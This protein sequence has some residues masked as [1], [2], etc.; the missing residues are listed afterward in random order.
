MLNMHPCRLTCPTIGNIPVI[1]NMLERKMPAEK[2]HQALDARVEIF[3][4][5]LCCGLFFSLHK[6]PLR[7]SLALHLPVALKIGHLGQLAHLGSVR[8]GK[9]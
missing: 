8:Q 6:L 3:H 1:A 7:S 4:M 9:D 2:S 5:S